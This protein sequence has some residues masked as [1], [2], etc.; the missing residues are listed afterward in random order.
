MMVTRG[1]GDLCHL[2][3]MFG[4]NTIVNSCFLLIRVHETGGNNYPYFP[5]LTVTGTHDVYVRIRRE[6][7]VE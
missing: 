1:E 5:F 6:F 2:P 3:F 4:T 7:R